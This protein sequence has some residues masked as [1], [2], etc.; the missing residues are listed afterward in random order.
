MPRAGQPGICS[1]STSLAQP[2]M[3]NLVCRV[4]LGYD[5]EWLICEKWAGSQGL[6]LCRTCGESAIV[7]L[8]D[9]QFWLIDIIL[10]LSPIAYTH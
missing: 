8:N 3:F 1:G 7:A 6:P 4:T 2:S 5:M 10:N 9:L